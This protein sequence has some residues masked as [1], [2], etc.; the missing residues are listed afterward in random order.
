MDDRT[1]PN[2]QPAYPTAP[3]PQQPYGQPPYPP[4]PGQFGQPPMW[5]GP[6]PLKP[7]QSFLKRTPV[8]IV[9]VLVTLV[10]GLAI[11]SASKNS[12]VSTGTASISGPSGTPS[13]ARSGA[14][15]ASSP[16]PASMGS[17][18]SLQGETSGGS[19]AI[20]L[21][22]IVYPAQ[23][24]DEFNTPDAGHSLVGVQFRIKN[25]GKGAYSDDPDADAVLI[26]SA[27]Q[28]YQSDLG[29]TIAE[30]VSLN[31]SLNLAP[32][33]TT[34]GFEVFEVPK[35]TK[36]AQVQYQLD[37]FVGSTAEWRIGD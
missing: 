5:G 14:A 6:P 2:D 21:V 27:G 23:G 19:I 25:T 31:S 11:G 4:Q 7:Q 1:T 12:S 32:G 10:I 20:T 13:A 9:V 35:G 16:A 28:Q 29:T 26:D 37:F 30:G 8:Y 34:L 33:D 24:G 22:K 3:Y 36:L 17:T 18:I 15:P